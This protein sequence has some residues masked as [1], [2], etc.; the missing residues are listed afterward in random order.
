M[1]QSGWLGVVGI[2]G[3]AG[4]PAGLNE[5]ERQ[6]LVTV[7]EDGSDLRLRLL[8]AWWEHFARSSVGGAG[9]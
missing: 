6:G 9:P 1:I 3:S 7:L 8:Q 4:F 5:L 2:L